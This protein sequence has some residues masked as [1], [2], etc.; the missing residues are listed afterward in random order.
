MNVF[1]L[2]YIVLYLLISGVIFKSLQAIRTEQWFKQ[3]RMQDIQVILM[4][5]SMGI[6]YLVTNFIVDLIKYTNQIF[7]L[8]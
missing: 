1:A 3:N 7:I 6:S 2:T 5:L 8:F 4:S